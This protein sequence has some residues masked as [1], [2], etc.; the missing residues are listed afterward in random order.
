MQCPIRALVELLECA[1]QGIY[2]RASQYDSTVSIGPIEAAVRRHIRG[3]DL[4]QLGRFLADPAGS[5]FVWNEAPA[6]VSSN[7]DPLPAP[8]LTSCMQDP[9][10][11]ATGVTKTACPPDGST[12]AFEAL[13]QDVQR[14]LDR[15][16]QATAR[17]MPPDNDV[18]DPGRLVKQWMALLTAQARGQLMVLL[19]SEGSESRLGVIARAIL[20]GAS[21]TELELAVA[22][23]S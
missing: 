11:G 9:S 6:D 15:L 23:P 16:V 8:G 5:G 10:L 19:L 22:L 4:A 1:I 3:L 17:A 18:V 20:A 2:S 7:W 14:A 13:G 21:W 12:T